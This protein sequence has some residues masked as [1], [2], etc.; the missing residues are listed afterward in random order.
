MVKWM[1]WLSLT[2]TF[3]NILVRRTV[4]IIK[5]YGNPKD[6]WPPHG[7]P[8]QHSTSHHSFFRVT[9]KTV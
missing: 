4:E 7:H 1:I 6:T 9:D 2:C 3:G 5:K 8:G